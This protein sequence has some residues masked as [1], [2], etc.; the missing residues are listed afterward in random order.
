MAVH[1]VDPAAQHV[2]PDPERE[3][4]LEPHRD[5]FSPANRSW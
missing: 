1:T 4:A 3:V 2:R 5:S